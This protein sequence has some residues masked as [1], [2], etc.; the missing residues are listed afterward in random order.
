MIFC[1]ILATLLK[2]H[3]GLVALE[4]HVH[5]SNLDAFPPSGIMFHCFL[6]QNTVVTYGP[7]MEFVVMIQERMLKR[8][9][10]SIK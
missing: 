2:K 9:T 4:H 7:S 10:K 5:I 8:P 6:Q 1:P 3:N